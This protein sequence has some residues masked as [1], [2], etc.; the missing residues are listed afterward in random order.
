MFTQQSEVNDNTSLRWG[1]CLTLFQTGSW[2][3]FIDSRNSHK[4]AAVYTVHTSSIRIFNCLYFPNVTLKTD[5]FSAS[6]I[7]CTPLVSQVRVGKHETGGSRVFFNSQLV[8]WAVN[9]DLVSYTPSSLE[10]LKINCQ[11]A[12]LTGFKLRLNSLMITSQIIICRP[13]QAKICH[14]LMATQRRITIR[15][16][17]GL[18]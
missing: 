15:N 13:N 6:Q 5:I 16:H 1:T 10:C 3:L 2:M 9:G 14:N 17:S 8:T 7:D 4:I 11:T 18:R 12:P